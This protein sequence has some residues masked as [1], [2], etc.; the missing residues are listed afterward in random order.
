VF[1]PEVHITSTSRVDTFER[2]KVLNF[3][4]PTGS[5]TIFYYN[6][7]GVA[8]SVPFDFIPRI[9][10]TDV[11]HANT[12]LDPSPS[13]AQTGEQASARVVVR[14]RGIQHQ[15]DHAGRAHAWRN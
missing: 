4:P 6:I 3:I 9:S 11:L 7:K 2:E 15:A 8:I 5:T 1:D 10:F 13:R 14:R 12:H